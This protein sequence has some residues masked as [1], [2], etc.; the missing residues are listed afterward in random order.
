M[1]VISQNPEEGWL[2]VEPQCVEDLWYL[3]KIVE[4]GDGV[5]GTSFRRF[6]VEGVEKDSGEK[7]K[8]H[9]K[10][11]AEQIEFAQSAL[12]LRVTGVIESGTPEEFVSIG[13]HHTLD[14]DLHER[15]K[16]HKKLSAYHWALLQEAKKKS[17]HVK[18][19]LI[20]M[21]E[22]QA[23]PAE[24]QLQGLTFLGEMSFRGSKKD[25]K[26]FEEAT[27][28][29]FAEIAKT[30]EGKEKIVVAGPGFAK[31]NFKKY[32]TEKHP[33][34]AKKTSFEYASTAEKSGVYE[35]LKRGVIEKALGEQRLAQE[36][37]LLEKFK[38]SIGRDDHKN[39][40]G[41]DAVQ[42]AVLAGAAQHVLVSDT[43]IKN[44]TVSTIME[45]ARQMGAQLH[46]FDS[47]NETGQELKNYGVVALL[48]YPLWT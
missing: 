25:P 34:V 41:L 21:D 44:K 18:A 33:D 30:L 20:V 3:Q 26:A 47:E 4:P 6:K 28:T 35:L 15:V 13:S 46:V 19:F 5:E 36:F 10:I 1:K 2:K 8:V 12:K 24:L 23:I 31:D 42:H 7:K 40:Y 37:A 16:I 48:R 32:L 11:R 38:E 29:F 39:A 22:H 27:K 17:K 14:V 43:L 9:L 45:T